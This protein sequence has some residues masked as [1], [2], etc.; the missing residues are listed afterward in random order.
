[1]LSISPEVATALAIRLVQYLEPIDSGCILSH[2]HV[3]PVTGYSSIATG[4]RGCVAT[5]YA[6]RIMYT[7]I[8]GPIPDG[9]TLDHLCEVTNCVNPDHLEPVTIGVNVLRSTKN[10]MA[11]HA[12]K[13][14]CPKGHPYANTKAG[15][16]RYCPTCQV[17]RNIASR[18]R[19][20]A[21]GLPPG[22]E[23]HGTTGGYGNWGCRCELC[24]A[25]SRAAYLKRR[26]EAT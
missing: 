25:A 21:Q 10:P 6:H 20:H 26:D 13:T 7:H 14:A 23:R 17:A 5:Y 12:R 2:Y 16:H 4:M 8:V 11:I 19:R 18:E 24:K 3:N 9:L 1:M 22:D 15:R